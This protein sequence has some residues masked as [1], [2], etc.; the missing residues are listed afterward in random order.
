MKYTHTANFKGFGYAYPTGYIEKRK[1]R[2]TKRYWIDEHG[3]KYRKC[4][5]VKVVRAYTG[6]D[7]MLGSI[8]ELA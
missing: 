4:D 5:G 2:E 1:L 6:L 7:L 3:I 8:K